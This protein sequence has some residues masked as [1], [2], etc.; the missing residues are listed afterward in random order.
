MV[1]LEKI[2]AAS[3]SVKQG[4]ET[5]DEIEHFVSVIRRVVVSKAVGNNLE[6]TLPIEHPFLTHDISFSPH[7]YPRHLI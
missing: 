4:T 7:S 6:V 3:W 5:V 2:L 1:N